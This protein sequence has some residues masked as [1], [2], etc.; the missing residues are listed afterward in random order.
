MLATALVSQKPSVI[1]SQLIQDF[2]WLDSVSEWP[3]LVDTSQQ[4]IVSKTDQG[5]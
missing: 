3:S 4:W 1:A 2:Y 5:K